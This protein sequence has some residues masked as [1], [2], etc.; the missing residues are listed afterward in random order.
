MLAA[1]G[2]QVVKG[3]IPD[4]LAELQHED[5]RIL[6][7]PFDVALLGRR[8]LV[9]PARAAIARRLAVA[10]AY[11]TPAKESEDVEDRLAEISRKAQVSGA[12]LTAMGE[13]LDSL[14]LPYD[15]WETLY[16]LR[17]Q[18]EHPGVSAGSAQ[19]S[20]GRSAAPGRPAPDA[21]EASTQ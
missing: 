6:V 16:W 3:L 10:D 15:H 13:H 11:L 17:L 8:E 9:A 7:Y 18:A 4:D 5:L 2:G 1:V 20:N 21:V 12:E 14:D 19:H